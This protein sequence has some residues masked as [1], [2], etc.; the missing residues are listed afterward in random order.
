MTLRTIL[1]RL[2][3]SLAIV[4]GVLWLA[5]H[6]GQLD[7]VLIENAIRSL[8]PWGPVAHVALFALGTVLFVPG[9]LFGLAGGVLFGPVWGTILNLTGATLGATGAFLVARYAAADWVRE[10]AGT[11]GSGLS[12][13]WRPKA[14]VS[15]P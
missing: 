11:R 4:A 14:G 5:L 9:A 12:R 13:A 7:P 3:L 15:S 10:K 6:R 2:L 8:G 1:P